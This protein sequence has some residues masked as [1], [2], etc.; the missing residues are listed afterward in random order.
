MTRTTIIDGWITK[1]VVE[2]ALSRWPVDGWYRY[3]DAHAR[4]STLC[5]WRRIPMELR[6]LLSRL[7]RKFRRHSIPDTSLWGAGLCEM[8]P[9]DFL[10]EHLDHDVHPHLGMRRTHNAI[11]FLGGNG[12]LIVGKGAEQRV[13]PLPGR[14]CVFD[15]TDDAYHRVEAVT[16]TRRTLSVY[17][18]DPSEWKNPEWANRTRAAYTGA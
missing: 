13:S 6:R 3:D 18:Y 11:L 10:A 4:K 12:D 14:V 17:F 2:D 9:G 1:D 7:S 5:D 16:E 8:R 15:T